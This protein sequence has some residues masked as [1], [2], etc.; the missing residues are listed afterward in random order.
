MTTTIQQTAKK[1]KLLILLGVIGILFGFMFVFSPE[2][3]GLGG[4]LLFVGLVCLL[5]G[6][7]GRWWHHA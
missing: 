1:F 3:Q 6:K 5:W 4:V 7:I 2:T